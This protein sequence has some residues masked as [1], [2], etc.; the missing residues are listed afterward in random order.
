MVAWLPLLLQ[1][2][3]IQRLRDSK[4]QRLKDSKTLKCRLFQ[5]VAAD[6]A[7]GEN[8]SSKTM[9]FKIEIQDSCAKGSPH[10]FAAAEAS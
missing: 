9:E 6:L 3:K 5:G 8:K 2:R 7:A 1:R 4:T 10:K